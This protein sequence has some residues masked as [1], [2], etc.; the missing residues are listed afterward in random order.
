[1]ASVV[2]LSVNFTIALLVALRAYAISARGHL[3][4]LKMVLRRL[5]KSPG[6]FLFPPASQPQ[7]GITRPAAEW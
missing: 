3:Q 4:L 1:M 6:N 2:S 7:G 5:V